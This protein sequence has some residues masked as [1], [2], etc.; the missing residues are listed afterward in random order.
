MTANTL[1]KDKTLP[2]TEDGCIHNREDSVAD[3][4]IW[5]YCFYEQC[6]DVVVCKLI[7]L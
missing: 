2:S 3:T 5:S 1:I 4:R 6:R 7:I